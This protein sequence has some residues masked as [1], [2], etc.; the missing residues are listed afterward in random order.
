MSYI[1]CT[2]KLVIR[3]DIKQSSYDYLMESPLTINVHLIL[4]INPHLRKQVKNCPIS[5]KRPS[6]ISVMCQTVSQV[7]LVFPILT[8]SSNEDHG[9]RKTT[10]CSSYRVNT[11]YSYSYRSHKEGSVQV[12]SYDHQCHYMCSITCKLSIVK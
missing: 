9:E 3:D 4:T 6:I 12:T 10:R 8:V 7:C 11:V 1:F 5:R 2:C